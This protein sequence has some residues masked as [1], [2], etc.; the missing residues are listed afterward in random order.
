MWQ[1]RGQQRPPFAREP[2][3]GQESV[4]DYPRPPALVADQ[5]RVQVRCGGVLIADTTDALRLLETASPPT[6]YLP[7]ADVRREWL[8]P[9][10]H[11][12]WCEWKGEASYWSFVNGGRRVA[13]VAWSYA[14]PAA[15]Y[16]ELAGHFGFYP[17]RAECYVDGERVQA[18]P[19]G[20]YG[21][22]ITA[23]IVGP[24]KGESGTGNW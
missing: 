8:V 17:A 6:F 18:Q 4:W 15:P 16:A 14:S 21:G 3:P 22:W 5:R 1:Y 10:R 12:S 20:F 9:S 2:G 23:D 7:P 24:C 13:D 11:R 19:G